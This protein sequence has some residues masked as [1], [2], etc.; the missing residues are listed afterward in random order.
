MSEP[1]GRTIPFTS[2][3]SIRGLLADERVR[4]VIVGGFN[5]VFGYALYVAFHEIFDIPYLFSLYGSYVIA[6]LVAFVLHRQFTYRRAGTGNLALDF[7]RFQ[8][9]YVVSLLFNTVALPLLVEV[10]HWHPTVAQAVI[11]VFTAVVSYFGHK[12]FSFRRAPQD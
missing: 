9:V 3:R 1:A 7:V 8:G 5:T 11:V 2:I 12:F 10:A 6:T 4:F